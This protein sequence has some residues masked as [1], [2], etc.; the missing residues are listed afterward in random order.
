[1]ANTAV[2]SSIDE[3]NLGAP[4]RPGGAHVTQIS[5]SEKHHFSSAAAVPPPLPPPNPKSSH[6]AALAESRKKPSEYFC[7]NAA[8][9]V[10]SSYGGL[11]FFSLAS[12]SD[13][14]MCQVDATAK[15]EEETSLSSS[16]P[17]LKS[18]ESHSS[19]QADGATISALYATVNKVITTEFV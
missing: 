3:L 14:S 9:L 4:K 16:S 10:R 2:Y 5:E 8:V 1:M 12:N 15:V 19:D 13:E 17:S 11:I 7:M 6:S 18:V